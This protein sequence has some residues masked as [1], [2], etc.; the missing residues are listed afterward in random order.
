[1]N[2]AKELLKMIEETEGGAVQIK[3]ATGTTIESASEI[4]DKLR[5][6]GLDP[7]INIVG[8]ETFVEFNVALTDDQ[9]ANALELLKPIL[10]NSGATE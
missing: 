8:E 9:Y 5:E 6:A 10:F 1:M 2:K 3:V 4:F 7:V